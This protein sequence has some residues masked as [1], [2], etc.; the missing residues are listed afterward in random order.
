MIYVGCDLGISSAKVVLTENKTI[1]SYE[2]VHYK[3]F[4]N[5]AVVMALEGA[6]RKA[7][8]SEN[9]IGSYL[10]SGFGKRAI[11]FTDQVH[12]GALCLVRGI[13]ELN[14]QVKTI[15]DVGGHFMLAANITPDWKL[16][17]MAKVEDCISGTGMFIEMMAGMLEMS[18]DEMVESPVASEKL[19]KLATTC[20]VFA[21]SE[22]ITRINEGYDR[23]EVFAAITRSIAGRIISL[24]RKTNILP[25]VA[26]AGGV[27]RFAGVTSEIENHL[28]IKF[29]DLKGIDPRIIAAFGAALLAEENH[30]EGV[31]P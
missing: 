31:R 7:N 10:A 26:M 19:V 16:I 9:E 15:I 11:P 17:N 8:R 23:L 5:Q 14:P 27:A 28:E 25:E 20:A 3:S 4:P 12:S 6:L 2:I 29:A 18:M 13:R 24:A 21:E 22:V 30:S 1:L